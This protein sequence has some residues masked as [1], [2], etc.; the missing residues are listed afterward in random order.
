[1]QIS[2]IIENFKSSLNRLDRKLFWQL[3]ILN[4]VILLLLILLFATFLVKSWDGV[5]IIKILTLF[6]LAVGVVVVLINYI[7]STDFWQ[8]NEKFEQSKFY[9]EELSK[10]L[11]MSLTFLAEERYNWKKWD[12]SADLIKKTVLLK[13]E[14]SKVSTPSFAS[15]VEARLT[16]YQNRLRLVL[17]G[18]DAQMLLG[19]F[20]NLQQN[21]EIRKNETTVFP[22]G[23]SGE[24]F[25]TII[26]FALSGKIDIHSEVL[27]A[28]EI[29][30][31]SSKMPAVLEFARKV[32]LFAKNNE[33][34]IEWKRNVDECLADSS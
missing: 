32:S 27:T 33:K 12:I 4:A 5:I 11:E 28:S 20:S 23:V 25:T 29:T 24:A 14:L 34:Q 31:F 15:M 22:H 17:E 13:E 7:K 26:R 6:V 10:L 19:H 21:M 18:I 9:F 8:N 16:F 1:M 2:E 30:L 3:I